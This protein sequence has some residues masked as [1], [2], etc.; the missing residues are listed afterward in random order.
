MKK[1]L[2]IGTSG[3]NYPH[4][5][6]IFYPEK[7]SEKKWLEY[8]STCFRTVE[9]NNTFYRTPREK[10]LDGWFETAPEGFIFSVKASRYITH[11]KQLKDTEGHVKKFYG[12]VGRLGRKLGPV[13]FQLPSRFKLN[14]N[15]R[16]KLK[17]FL[18][19]LPPEQENVLEFRDPAWWD[20]KVYSLLEEHGAA[21]CC[22]SGLGMPPG[23]IITSDTAYFRFHGKDYSTSYTEEEL[24]NF[25][26]KIKRLD[27][28]RV[29]AYFNNDSN[30]YAVGNALRLKELFG[31]G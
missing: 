26:K 29:Y 13:L 22:V 15:N 12:L 17:K 30:A 21:F 18:S 31:D 8:Y 16:D 5:R 24:S 20:D 11:L 3:W 7:L 14:E 10:T 2:L 23:I 4:W 28:R 27:A 9:L 19:S 25:S 1:T 6:K